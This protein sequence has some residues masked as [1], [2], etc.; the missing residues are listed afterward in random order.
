MSAPTEDEIRQALIARRDQADGYADD[1]D[2]IDYLSDGLRSDRVWQTDGGEPGSGDDAMPHPRLAELLD[3]A[4]ERIAELLDAA[5]ERIAERC[6]AIALDE[7]TAAGLT[8]AAEYPDHL[9]GP[10]PTPEERLAIREGRV[11]ATV[12]A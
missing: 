2:W 9:R 4:Q 10:D 8:F 1:T 12:E 6:M 7:F 3:A 5:Q 11:L